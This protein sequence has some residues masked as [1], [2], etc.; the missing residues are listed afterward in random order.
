MNEGLKA[1]HARMKKQREA[2][3]Q[4]MG[5]ALKS[6]CRSGGGEASFAELRTEYLRQKLPW[7]FEHVDSERAMHYILRDVAKEVP[8]ERG[9]V[10]RGRYGRFTMY[11]LKGAS[12]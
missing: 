5:R 6:A 4:A 10:S 8:F 7:P 2:Q 1:S 12:R 11:R 3:A 9:V